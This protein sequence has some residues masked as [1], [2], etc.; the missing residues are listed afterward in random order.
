MYIITHRLTRLYRVWVTTC[1]WNGIREVFACENVNPGLWN[2]KYR[3]GNPQPAPQTKLNSGLVRLRKSAEITL[4]WALT[5]VPGFEHAPWLIYSA[6]SCLKKPLSNC[7]SGWKEIRN[8]PTSGNSLNTLR[9]QNKD[10]G[11]AAQTLLNKVKSCL[12]L[13]L[14]TRK[15][16][17]D[18]DWSKT[19]LD[20][21][22]WGDVCDLRACLHGGGGPHVGNVIRLGGVTRLSIKS[23]ILIWSRLHVRWGDSPHVTPPIWVPPSPCTQAL[24]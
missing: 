22:T 18:P 9:T 12:W 15:K 6:P 16:A 21:L 17:W 19:V 8:A 24:T 2:L 23:L 1:F 3:S 7:Q 14:E 10:L 13:R 20:S 5:C 11:A 4:F